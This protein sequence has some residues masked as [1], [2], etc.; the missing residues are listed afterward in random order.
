MVASPTPPLLSLLPLLV[1][2]LL[3]V[4]L[5]FSSCGELPHSIC[6]KKKGPS[7]S[8]QANPST[9]T[10]NDKINKRVTQATMIHLKNMIKWPL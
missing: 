3:S 10:T 7:I 1:H 4:Y 8:I 5:S 2:K 6:L 9:S